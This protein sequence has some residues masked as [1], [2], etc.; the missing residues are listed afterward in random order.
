MCHTNFEKMDKNSVVYFEKYRAL[1]SEI[2]KHAEYLEDTHRKHINCKNGCDLCCM[3]Y[4]IFP[5]EFYFIL[6]ELKENNIGNFSNNPVDKNTCV[7]LINH[8][9]SIYKQRPVICRTH[10]LPLLFANDDGNWE[11]SACE[12]NFTTYD[13]E[14]FEM[15]NTFPQDKYN[16]KL[17]VLNKE[18]I[19]SFKE[20]KYGEFDLIPLK[21]LINYM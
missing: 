19:A 9:C 17:F 5:V 8:S 4:S 1:R 16:S 18:F 2:D 12:L 10:G 7:F 21:E 11:L 6:N 14:E 20:K 3:D 15:G 13:F